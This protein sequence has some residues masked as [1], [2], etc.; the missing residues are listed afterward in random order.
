VEH[1]LQINR[2]SAYESIYNRHAFHEVCAWWA[3]KHLTELHKEKLLCICKRLLDR[4]G[5]EGYHLKKVVMGDET[6]IHH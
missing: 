5:A 2:G 6:W 4:Y 3:P 1:Q